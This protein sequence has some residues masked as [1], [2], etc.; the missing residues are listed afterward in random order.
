MKQK[1]DFMFKIILIGESQV[2]KT[3]IVSRFLR[4][5]FDENSRSTIGIEFG[6]K[7][8]TIDGHQIKAQFWDTSGLERYK[9]INFAYY[10]GVKGAFVVYDITNK[11]SFDKVDNRMNDLKKL[12]PKDVSII[13]IGNKNDLEDN[14]E[15]MKEEGE[16][17]AKKHNAYFIETSALTGENLDKAFEMM[18]TELYQKEKNSNEK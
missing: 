1:Y 7:I 6:S 8:F 11:E 3:N 9:T 18:M 17:K 10:K 5:N 14:R 2:G 15:I 12:A 13:L 4:N 16:E